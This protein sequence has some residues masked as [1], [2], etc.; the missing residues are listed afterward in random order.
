ME[1]SKKETS[2]SI[3]HNR[4]IFYFAKEVNQESCTELIK[5]ILEIN[6]QTPEDVDH[7]QLIINSPG[8]NLTDGFAVCDIM[9]GSKTQIYTYGIGCIASAGLLIFMAGEKGY[10][11]ITPNTSIL[12][13][14]WQWGSYGKEHELFA[15]T[16]EFDLTRQRMIAH[17]K[18]YTGLTEKKILK[19]LLPAH[20]VWIEAEE[21]LELGLADEIRKF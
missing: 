12:S 13:H 18:K 17:Y 5:F 8:V 4:G 19:Y 20:D 9:A 2:R 7:I 14:Q 21:A 3:L 15:V 16:K 11:I 10:R 6:M 1:K